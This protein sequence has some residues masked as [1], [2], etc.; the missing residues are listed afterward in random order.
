MT[1]AVKI[2]NLS[3]DYGKQPVLNH[4]N[5]SVNAGE[6]IGV[7]G[8]NGAG[9]TTLLRLMQAQLPINGEISIFGHQA[10]DT[11][12]RDWLG[13]MPQG[14]LKLPGVTVQELLR[15]LSASYSN[16][17]NI[18]QLMRDN[19]IAALRKKR[20]DRLSGGQLRRVTFLSALVGQPRLLF[21]DEPTVGM[22]VT[23]REKLWLQVKQM[24][25]A[26]V[27]IMITS[28]YLE[29]LQD[30]ADR[31]LILKSG[32]I[33]FQGTFS[34]LQEAHVQTLFRFTSSLSEPQLLHLPGVQSVT[35]VGSYWE[36]TSN[37]GDQTLGALSRQLSHVHE[38][39]VTKQSL[40]DIFS[41]MMRQEAAK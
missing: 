10:H 37:D 14:D 32:R 33:R 13:A 17:A 34:E 29:E 18:D 7:I 35:K 11:R 4:I 24:Q 26:G 15:N 25:R 38:L 21:L 19:G 22:D 27:T 12:V 39:S 31:L 6:M 3:F 23:A 2:Q 41:E 9:K 40:A 8:E 20:I 28:H 30:V 1:E 16:P 36:L 5:F